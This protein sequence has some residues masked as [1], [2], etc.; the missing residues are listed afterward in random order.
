LRASWL[1]ALDG[2]Q[3][4]LGGRVH[5]YVVAWRVLVG[6]YVGA[7]VAAVV[8]VNGDQGDAPAAACLVGAAGL[9]LGWGTGS[10]WGAV[11]PWLLIPLALPFGDANQV[12]GG[13]DAYLVALLAA[14]SAAISTVLIMAAAG[15]RI[16]YNRHRSRARLR[17]VPA[18]LPNEAPGRDA[19]QVLG[20]PPRR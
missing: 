11:V 6:L 20:P 4:R 17:E 9:A 16:L 7:A 18:R 10:G 3:L 5:S 1:D 14:V 19:V 15:T 2:P 8:I 12:A 13:G